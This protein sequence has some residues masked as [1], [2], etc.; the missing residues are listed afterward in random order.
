MSKGYA[1]IFRLRENGPPGLRSKI[2]IKF[3]NMPRILTTFKPEGHGMA[4]YMKN[5]AAKVRKVRPR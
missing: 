2:S 4:S 5:L 1:S 3:K